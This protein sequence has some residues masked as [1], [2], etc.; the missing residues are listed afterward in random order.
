MVRQIADIIHWFVDT[1]TVGGLIVISVY[2]IAFVLFVIMTRWILA[3]GRVP[4]E[5]DEEEVA[6]EGA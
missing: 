4:D 1:P 6:H 5:S 2:S 3:G